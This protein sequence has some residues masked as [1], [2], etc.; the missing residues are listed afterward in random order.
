MTK[1]EI[2]ILKQKTIEL[3]NQGF[4]IVQTS[5]LLHTS[6][7]SVSKYFKSAGILTDDRGGKNAKITY[8]PFYPRTEEGDYWIG[9]LIADGNIASNK[10]HAIALSQGGH[11]KDHMLK[12]HKFLREIPTLHYDSQNRITVLF[13]HP[14]TAD[15]LGSI[16]IEPKKSYTIELK[17]P[18]NWDIVRGYFDGDGGFS[19]T[20]HEGWKDY[21]SVKFTS[22]SSKI[23]Y[24]LQEFL[25]DEG[26]RSNVRCESEHIYRLTIS[27]DSR[28]VF[29]FKMYK[30]AKVFME[31]K[32]Q[33]WD[34]FFRA[35]VKYRELLGTLEGGNQQLNLSSNRFESSTTSSE[36]LVDNNSTTSAVHQNHDL[37]KVCLQTNFGSNS[38]SMMI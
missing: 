29:C 21:L 20:K 33:I 12:Y 7:Q 8:N 17:I 22:G 35:Q 36:S 31:R 27:G 13:G 2:Q 16:G 3:G 6:R 30:N 23:L 5:K 4:T 32:F 26:I 38:D 25:I 14:P 1:N 10:K 24:Q 9:M 11:N 15:W 37:T 18:F 19:L 34:N 28:F